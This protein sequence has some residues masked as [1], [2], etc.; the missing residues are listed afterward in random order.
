[1][2]CSVSI[3]SLLQ[4]R[5]IINIVLLKVAYSSKTIDWAS[6]VP[7]QCVNSYQSYFSIFHTWRRVRDSMLVC[8][9]IGAFT[10]SENFFF[11]F[12][13]FVF[14]FYLFYLFKIFLLF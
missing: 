4:M 13:F 5:V 11:L 9:L 3:R 14:V 7:Y 2:F 10:F 1:M 6:D 8:S 12:F